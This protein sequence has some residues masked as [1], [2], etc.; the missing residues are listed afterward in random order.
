MLKNPKLDVV[1]INAYAK[2]GQNPSNFF[3]DIEQKQKCFR[4]TTSKQYTHP[5]Y[6]VCVWGGGGGAYVC[7]WGGGYKN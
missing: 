1:N 5:P 6:F 7:V 3:Q 2:F 4:W